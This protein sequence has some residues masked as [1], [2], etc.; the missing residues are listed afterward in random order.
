MVEL[1]YIGSRGRQLTLKTD[2]N[3]APPTVGVTNQN[4][5]RPFAN[6]SPALR[7]VGTA[8]SSGTLDYHAFTFKG[9]KRFSN[10]FSALVSYTWGKAIDIVSDNDGTVSLTNIFNRDYDRGP[11]SYDITHSF[12]T[13]FLYELPFARTHKLGG[14]QVNGIL[15]YRTG[16]PLTITQTGN[17]ASTGT[18]NRPNRLAEGYASDKTIEHWFDPAAFQRPADTTGTYGDSGRNILRGPSNFNIDMSLVKNTKI[19]PI[20][21][22]LRIEAFNVLNHPQFGQPNGQL[23]NANFGVITS[24]AT[25]SCQTCGTAERQIQ[26]GVKMRF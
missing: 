16:L 25:P 18:G 1:A 3:Q 5:N 12:V 13:S 10:G 11:A 17:I 23:G 15:A 21:T 19:G 24:S 20:D 22:E 26:F 14:W 4:V 9:V 6:V 8:E 2:Q 7:T